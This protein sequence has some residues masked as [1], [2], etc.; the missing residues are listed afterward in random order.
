MIKSSADLTDC[1]KWEK[2]E[3]GNVINRLIKSPTALTDFHR[4]KLQEIFT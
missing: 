1:V 3:N 4:K 2:N